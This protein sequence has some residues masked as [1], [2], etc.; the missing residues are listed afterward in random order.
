MFALLLILLYSANNLL[1]ESKADT[2][3][4]KAWRDTFRVVKAQKIEI[5]SINPMLYYRPKPFEFAKNVVEFYPQISPLLHN[6]KILLHLI[7]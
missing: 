2:L 7:T 6:H 5:D 4:N 3:V 1:A